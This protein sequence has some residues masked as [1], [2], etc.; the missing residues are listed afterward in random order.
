MSLNIKFLNASKTL[1][2]I[3]K[4]LSFYFIT[5]KDFLQI[6]SNKGKCLDNLD[7]FSTCQGIGLVM[8]SQ[9]F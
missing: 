8:Y 6:C 1:I 7:F 5:S 9:F 4:I 2:S 3:S